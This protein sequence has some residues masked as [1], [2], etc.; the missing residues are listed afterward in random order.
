MSSMLALALSLGLSAAHA[1]SNPPPTQA[2]LRL[3]VDVLMPRGWAIEAQSRD[4]VVARSAD[5]RSTAWVAVGAFQ[6]DVDD[7]MAKANGARLVNRLKAVGYDDVTVTRSSVVDLGARSAASVRAEGRAADQPDF[8]AHLLSWP[9]EGGMVHVGIR[10]PLQDEARLE[11]ALDG[12]VASVSGGNPPADLSALAGTGKGENG[13][14]APLPAGWRLAQT[15]ELGSLAPFFANLGMDK[16]DPATCWAA[17]D[18]DV[19][20]KVDVL[21]ACHRDLRIGILD[22][23]SVELE[24]QSIRNQLFGA[25]GA[26][27]AAPAVLSGGDRL[28]LVYDMPA[29]GSHDADLAVT[30]YGTGALVTYAVVDTARG[31]TARAVLEPVVLNAAFPGDDNGLPSHGAA[32][33]LGYVMRVHTVLFA[34]SFTPFLAGAAL[35]MKRG[36]DR[37]RAEREER[38]F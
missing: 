29:D 18:P 17:I 21:V 5:G 36:A 26:E 25:K 31:A 11:R 30:P 6:F 28:S 9:V 35:W 14:S 19:T 38:G 34:L 13:V 16:L 7:A 4:Q 20:D 8:V 23:S 1:E 27:K 3:G 12:W 22:E 32:A 33:W 10:G 2:D 24:D 15:A 37:Q